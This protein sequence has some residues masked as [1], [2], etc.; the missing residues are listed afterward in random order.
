[1]P[2]VRDGGS[3][4]P[5]SPEPALPPGGV[6]LVRN[7][8]LSVGV[9]A[10]TVGGLLAI[11]WR[12]E[13]LRAVSMLRGRTL[14][15]ALALV[16]ASWVTDATRTWLVARALGHPVRLGLALRAVLTGAFV[17]SVTP[18]MAGGGATQA[19]VLSQGGM[20]YPLGLA[21][22]SA[23][24]VIGQTVL[25]LA[26]A[27]I[28]FFGPP[29][30]GLPVVRTALRGVLAVYAVGLA[31]VAAA[32][33]QLEV[34]AG[35]VDRVLARLQ[36][37]LPGAAVQLRRLRRRSRSFLSSAAC[38]VR[39]V[40]QGRPATTAAVAAV[41]ALYYLLV[42]AVAPIIGR[43]I[44]VGLPATTLIAVQCPLF[45]LGAL[46][47]TPG[48]AGGVE[49]AMAAVAA[50]HMPLPAVGVFVAAWRLA[51]FYPSVVVGAAATLISLRWIQPSGGALRARAR[52]PA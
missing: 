2:Q 10:I 17:S 15:A 38:G 39:T 52:N 41:S 3:L 14:A 8:L 26:S 44:N 28:A 23:I 43:P 21:S 32:L 30:P 11:T 4:A 19:F 37:V 20:P 50:P 25:W 48:G 35:P 51:T 12:P 42:F 45:L 31:F 1:M 18:F 16:A 27:A 49:A 6:A 22:V 5:E 34:L 9:T 36:R 47:P 40:F 33:M 13:S 29:V 46:V 7:L 24:G